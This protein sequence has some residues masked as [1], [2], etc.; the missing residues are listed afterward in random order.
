MDVLDKIDKLR[1]E[2][3]WSFYKL[4]EESML[5]QSTLA[6]MFSRGTQPS[7]STLESICNGLGISLSRFF[8]ENHDDLSTSKNL[9]LIERFNKLDANQQY[10]VLQLIKNL[11]NTKKE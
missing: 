2:K 11:S 4:A 8:A 5:S 6:N 9:D 7:I 3:N 10:A 1:T